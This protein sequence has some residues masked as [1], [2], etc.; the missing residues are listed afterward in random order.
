MKKCGWF[1]PVTSLP[2][3]HNSTFSHVGCVSTEFFRNV[4]L[5]VELVHENISLPVVGLRERE[6]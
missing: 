4:I 1:A 6:I 5:F 3:P 2:R